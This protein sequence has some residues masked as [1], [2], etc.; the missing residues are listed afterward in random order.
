MEIF[1]DIYSKNSSFK[2]NLDLLPW[3]HKSLLP[4]ETEESTCECEGELKIK[5]KKERGQGIERET[6]NFKKK[7]KTREVEE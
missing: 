2:E 5:F 6:E 7:K 1:A 4:S 3:V